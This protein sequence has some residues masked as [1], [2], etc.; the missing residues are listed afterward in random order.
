LAGL[1]IGAQAGGWNWATNATS[2]DL[3]PA[4]TRVPIP[5][6]G[7]FSGGD[8]GIVGTNP[9]DVISL[10]VV[11]WGSSYADPF[12]AGAASSPLGWFNPINITLGSDFSPGI[13]MNAA[14]MTS[15]SLIIPEASTFV[16]AA[17]VLIIRRCKRS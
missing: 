8:L 3:L 9:N 12:S 10:Y 4:V 17:L 11:G 13:N 1:F 7:T 5:T 14:G 15:F 6:T 2:G 16:L